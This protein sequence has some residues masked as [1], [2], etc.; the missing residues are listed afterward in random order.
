MEFDGGVT[1]AFSKIK[2]LISKK[3]YTTLGIMRNNLVEE[4]EKIIRLERP[5]GKNTTRKAQIDMAIKKITQGI[6]EELREKDSKIGEDIPYTPSGN[7]LDFIK[8]QEATIN[9]NISEKTSKAEIKQW[10]HNWVNSAFGAADFTAQDKEYI[11][12]RANAYLEDNTDVDTGTF[13]NNI[14]ET[15]SEANPYL[16]ENT[17]VDTGTFKNNIIETV[18]E[19]NPCDTGVFYDPCSGNPMETNTLQALERRV[20]EIRDRSTEH[21]STE[22]FPDSIATRLD[23]LLH[24]LNRP[25]PPNASLFKYTINGQL[26]EACWDIVFALSLID[27]YERTDNFFMIHKRAEHIQANESQIYSNNPIEY[28]RKR[29]VNEGAS[30]ASDITFCYK[31]PK[32]PIADDVCSGPKLSAQA[33]VAGAGPLEDTRTKFYFCSSKFYKR[34]ASKSAESFDIQKIYTA[35]KKLHQDYDVKIILLVKDK[36]AVETKLKNARNK[37]ISEE[38]SRTYGERDLFAA[39][40][41]I[42]D[43]SRRKIE[44]TVDEASLK[45]ILGIKDKMK[46]FLSPRLHQHMAILKIQKAI[47]KFKQEGGNNKFLVGILPRGG[48]TYIAGGLVSSLQPKRIVVLLGAKSETLS[49]FTHDLFQYYQDFYD[50]EV[51]DVLDGGADAEINPSK[52]Y[53]FVMSVELYKKENS[54]RKILIE[55]KTGTHKADLFICDEAHLKQ[56]TSKAIKELEEGTAAVVS[57]REEDREEESGL[58]QLNTVISTE[59]PVVYMTGT[60]IK[61][62]KVFDIPDDHVAIWE[63]RDIQEGKNIVDNEQYFKDNF[64]GIYEEALAKCFSYGETYETIQAMYRRF[65]NLYLLSTQFTD[66]AK[67]SFLEQ[68]KGGEQVGFPTI[69]HLFQVRKDYSPEK[70]TPKDWHTGFTNPTGMTRLIN[71]LSP[72]PIE[73]DSTPIQ[74]VMRRIDRIS[75]RIGDRLSFFTKDFVVHSQLWFLP[76]MQGHPLIK[77]M[78]ALAGTIFKSSWYKKHFNIL[79][80]SSSAE[81]SNIP[82]SKDGRIQI[83]GGTFSW[84]CPSKR[85]NDT[86]KACILREEAAA[87][88]EG[89]GLV[90]LAQN[91]L[92]LGISLTCVDIVVLLDAGDKVDERIQKMYRALTESTHKKGGYIVDL[93]YFR[94]V[95]AIMNYQIQASKTRH[96]K[97][98]YADSGLKEAF[99]SM[100]ETYSIDDD[101]DIYG[102]KEEGGESRIEAET[103]PELRRVLSTAQKGRGDG[104]MITTAGEAMNADI[105]DVLKD[106]YGR[107]LDSILG[108]LAD[109]SM[110]HTLR[111]EGNGVE[112][113]EEEKDEEPRQRN[114]PLFPE[115]VENDPVNKRKAFIDMFK[116]T[117]KIGIFGTR[118]KTLSQLVAG[119]KKGDEASN[120]LQGVIYDTLIKR[121]EIVDSAEPTF[122]MK[123]IVHEL[124]EIIKQKKNSSYSGMKEAFNSKDT[125]KNTFEEVLRYII[126][127]LTPKDAERHKFGEVFTPLTLVDEMLS[128]LPPTVWTK[129][130]Y[131]WLD[132]ANGIGN[133][134]IKAF[135]GQSEGE[136]KYLGLFN[137]LEKEIP[138]P[139]KRCKWIIENMLYMIDINSKNNLIAKRLFE[140]LCP[141]AKANIEQIDKKEGFL[142]DTPLKFNG[143]EV[144]EFDI[145]MGNPPFNK[146][147]VRVA[148][149]TNKTR[150]ERKDLGIQ[151][152]MSESVFWF[153]FVDK[154]LTKGVLKPN[155]YLLFIHPITWFKPDR[156]GAHDLI[157]SKQVLNIKI[158]K[159][160]GAAQKLFGG[161]C[162]ISIAF[163]LLENKAATSQK[164]QFEYG[165][166]KDKREDVLLSIKSIITLNYNSIFNKVNNKCAL[167]GN[168][169]GLKHITINECDDNG[170]NNLIT[171]L[172]EKG[173]IK[174]VKSSVPHPDQTTPKVI[175]GGTYTPIV[176]FDKEGKYGLFKKGQRNYF[177]GED[178]DKINDYF[179]TK[180]S[181]M[182]LRCVKYEQDFIKPGYFPDVRSIDLEKIN[183]KTLANYFG[184]TQEERREIDQMPYPIHPTADNII[185]I[186]CAEL[187]GKIK[188]EKQSTRV[189]RKKR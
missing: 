182:I 80:V 20:R 189:T 60:Y 75:Q 51:V 188:E 22:K 14:I 142:K 144:K 172:E 19:A 52:K 173:T 163:Y 101:L 91:M 69:T 73:G 115:H 181:T 97:E 177:I 185:K 121:G 54:S 122:V 15:V 57:A 44:G 34:D 43:L 17:D 58:D 162:K 117:M 95:T 87:R 12:R 124:E 128:K 98:V 111:K 30:G 126:D 72:R 38:A 42:Y 107:H 10:T 129:K 48:K 36:A 74:S 90:I 132:P 104:T 39:L 105:E 24:I 1:K 68:S 158:Y 139:A 174:Y 110:K 93:N 2:A 82:N 56:T 140:K 41:K 50:Y 152:D 4:G 180:L 151:D 154:M 100:I 168:T 136:H 6:P 145:V 7:V 55:L 137:G 170:K 131:K 11:R 99:N 175:V 18:S 113:A 45:D 186:S 29:N 53:I 146:G 3:N 183:D 133:F 167:F 76:A 160:D 155:G 116:T 159:N 165:D 108:E 28:L 141:G 118:Y 120:I 84:A 178:L 21:P 187:K 156:A 5:T 166:Y 184:F 150:K 103:L 138:D 157:L 26:Y 149:V 13:K 78:T 125:R 106:A 27:E 40:K 79:A 81:W 114:P 96:L 32:A 61:P 123:L 164:T 161:T 47:V 127:N 71:Y 112:R 49:Q 148:M 102:S 70:V 62:L 25:E 130:D 88:A 37:Y 147:A 109:N 171:I 179:K 86:L 8:E 31:N 135:I 23:L 35:V 64:P 59:V 67:T 153:K 33:C 119:L 63:Y 77:R 66:D 94:T 16:E 89:K 169:E 9:K 176:F 65:P 83:D 46:P 85:A 134:P 143:K 92:H